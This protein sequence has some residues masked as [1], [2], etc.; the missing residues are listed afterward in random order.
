VD[1]GRHGQDEFV[2]NQDIRE[3]YIAKLP[4]ITA[5]F[6]VMKIL[7]TTLGETGGDVIGQ[8]LHLGYLTGVGIFVGFLVIVLGL[9]LRTR[10]F[11]PVLFWAVILATSLVGTEISDYINNTLGLGYGT[12]AL[13]LIA[14][15]TVVLAMWRL[16]GNTMQVERITTRKDELLYWL[17]T[18]VSNTLGTSTGDY[19]AH[20]NNGLGAGYLTSTIIISAALVVLL[21]AHYLTPISGTLIFWAAYVLTR[22]LGANAGNALSK[23]PE[24]GGLGIGTYGASAVLLV[25]LLVCLGYQMVT[26]RQQTQVLTDNDSRHAR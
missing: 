8:T 11:H 25:L 13:I 2:A 22:P 26:H 16:T 4:L 1:I 5:L 15:L 3:Q 19:L 17:A 12:G 23:T 24:Q 10:S 21:A 20:D 14:A 9:Q 6:W 7:A 18:L